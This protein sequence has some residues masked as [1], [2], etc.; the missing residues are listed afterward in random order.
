MRE[1][2]LPPLPLT[3]GCQC[4]SVRYALSGPPVVFYVC[5][6]TECQKQ[7]ASG[8]GESLRVRA[9]DLAVTGDTAT[10]VRDAG[11]PSE[12]RCEFCP[13]CGSR[14][15]HRRAAYAETL[16]V[17]AGSLDDT[18]WLKPAGHIWT[19]SKQAWVAIPPDAL[20]Y[21]GQPNDGGAALAR[22]WREMTG[23]G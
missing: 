19:R 10:F 13:A 11:A 9:A 7:S 20:T 15:F 16:N 3:G 12:C 22:R 14:L 6:C 21:D 2:A 4:G 1:I 8:F 23:A 18:S 17:K 5:H